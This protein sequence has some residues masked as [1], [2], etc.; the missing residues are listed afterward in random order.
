MTL[1]LIRVV[2]ADDEPIARRGIRHLLAPHHDVEVI[3]EARNG[4]E[5][6]RLLKSLAPNLVFLDVQM[7]EMDGFAVLREVTP[8]RMPDVIFVTAYDN[9][10]VRAFEA[11]AL[12]YLVKPV[13]EARFQ[14]ALSRARERLGSKQALALSGRLATLVSLD[15]SASQAVVN[16]ALA[17]RRLV[18]PMSNS[19]LIVDVRDISWIQA[20]D[21]Y[22]A[23]HAGGKR[24]LVRESLT[25]LESRLNPIE[26][27][28]VHRGAIVNLAHVR[29]LKREESTLILRDGAR[30]P[31]SRR[32]RRRV[33]TALRRF[34][35]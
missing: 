14:D 7:P 8:D 24:H 31:L 22:S 12:D 26:F 30:L 27:V 2:I 13:N 15:R 5:A 3:G 1:N 29:E 33:Q 19:N 35:G 10:A 4:K 20:D 23:V 34:A 21:Y 9:F 17:P 16:G 25:S 6:V 11:H 18:I 28:R 32:R